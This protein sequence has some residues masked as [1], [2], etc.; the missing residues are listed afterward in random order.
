MAPKKLN[1]SEHSINTGEKKTLECRNR[2]NTQDVAPDAP[3]CPGSQPTPSQRGSK[4]I[5]CGCGVALYCMRSLVLS[6]DG[7]GAR[8]G[9]HT[10]MQSRVS[11]VPCCRYLLCNAELLLLLLLPRRI[12]GKS[13]RRASERLLLVPLSSSPLMGQGEMN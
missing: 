1:I 7:L 6:K 5:R 12:P 11:G 3:F 9:Q 13:N 8:G 4:H 2:Q 10:R